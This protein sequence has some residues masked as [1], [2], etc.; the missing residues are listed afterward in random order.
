VIKKAFSDEIIRPYMD[1]TIS[2]QEFAD[3]LNSYGSYIKDSVN[4]DAKPIWIGC[5]L[6]VHR[7]CINP[8]F[9]I[10]NELSYDRTMKMQTAKAKKEDES[11]FVMETSYWINVTGEEIGRKNHFI[12]SQGEKALDIIVSSFKKHN[13]IPDLFVISPFTTVIEGIKQM[14]NQSAEL[15]T[16]KDEVEIWLDNYCGT[17]HKFQGKEAKE[18]IFILGCDKKASGAVRGL[19]PNIL[20]FAAIRAKYRLYII[21]DYN[22]WKKSK[23][24]TITKGIID[25]YNLEHTKDVNKQLPG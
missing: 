21:G 4:E 7:R 12:T 11:K 17:V 3:R 5:P 9:D 6:I 10:S 24:F 23:I 13:E 8:M 19:K 1:K 25:N 16:H 14:V 20:N 2:V 15:K 22:V 18:V